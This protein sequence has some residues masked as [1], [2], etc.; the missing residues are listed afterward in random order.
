MELVRQARPSPF[1]VLFV[2]PDRDEVEPL[3]RALPPGTPIA[4]VPTAAAALQ[5]LSRHVPLLLVT[6]LNLPDMSGIDL[7]TRVHSTPA[8]RHVLLLIVTY[9]ATVGAKIAAFQA[10]ADDYLVKP[11]DP[12]QFMTHVRLVSLFRRIRS[13]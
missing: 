12:G 7:L 1:S 5:T 11:V 13:E 6:E 3:A 8:T 9:T 4:I 10:G 2:D